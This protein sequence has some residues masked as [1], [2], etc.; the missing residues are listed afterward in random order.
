M[1]QLYPY[2]SPVILTDDIFVEYGGSLQNNTPSK[3]AAAY[4]IAER[5]ASRDIGG[6]LTPTIV[7]G[8]YSY[9]E[10]FNSEGLILDWGYVNSVS[11]I[12]FL[13]TEESVYYT[14]SGTANVYASLR[15]PER[16]IVDIHTI[17][18]NC[19]CVS[20]ANPYPYQVQVV[21][22][23]GLSSGTAYAPNVL[24]ALTTYADI[25]MNEIIGYGNE[26]P[27]DVGIERFSNQDYRE[28]RYGMVHTTFGSSPRAM[29]ASK[30]LTELRKHRY[31]RW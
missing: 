26:A 3:R 30:L 10:A 11:V 25:I 19:N 28:E 13:D 4:Y 9:R 6:L 12:R 29:F 2:T 15:N 23:T 14:I 8:T 1:N 27:G 18:G 7:T 17:F 16:G 31:I 22:N 20:A 5:A 21:Y 24:L